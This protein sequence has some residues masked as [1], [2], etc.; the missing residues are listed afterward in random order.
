MF[1]AC[2]IRAHDCRLNLYPKAFKINYLIPLAMELKP[3]G[4]SEGNNCD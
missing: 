4:G 2:I 1:Y 3:K